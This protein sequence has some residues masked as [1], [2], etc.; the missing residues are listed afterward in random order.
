MLTVL[1]LLNTG[2]R[3]NL[4]GK[5]LIP[6]E[7][8][9]HIHH[10]KIPNL[11]KATQQPLRMNGKMLLHVGFCALFVQVW[12]SIFFY[13]AI[14]FLLGTSTINRFIHSIFPSEGKFLP[15]HSHPVPISVSPKSSKAANPNTVVV[16]TLTSDAPKTDI[17]V[18]KKPAP[19]R[20][21]PHALLLP[22]TECRVLV[23]TSAFGIHP[24]ELR[25]LEGNCQLMFAAHGVIGF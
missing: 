16:N 6:P 7:S 5:S 2:A 20:M 12:F 22:H 21:A 25:I 18:T 11:Q 15:W 14:D 10:G 13:L 8:N 17:K 3:L 4:L 24:V 19:I 9:H 23:I 1:C